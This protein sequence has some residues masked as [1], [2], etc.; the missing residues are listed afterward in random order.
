MEP[1]RGRNEK[2]TENQWVPKF[3]SG[4]RGIRTPGASQHGGF[5]DRC[6]R[7]LYH[8]SSAR[9]ASKRV[10]R[11]GYFFKLANFSSTFLQNRCKM[12]NFAA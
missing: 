1:R 11:Y 7:P 8:L 6:N 4:E 5:Q 2:P 3:M 9:T 10:Q 12:I